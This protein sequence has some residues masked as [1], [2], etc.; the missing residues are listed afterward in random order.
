M[1]VLCV[2][3]LIVID[4]PQTGANGVLSV[5]AGGMDRPLQNQTLLGLSPSASQAGRR[6]GSA[7]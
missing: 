5:R 6:V 1:T 4:Q 3:L 2:H 7:L